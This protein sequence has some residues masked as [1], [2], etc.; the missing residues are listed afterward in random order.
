MEST[1]IK[2]VW[3]VSVV[4]AGAVSVQQTSLRKKIAATWWNVSSYKLL[5]LQTKSIKH[6]KK[7]SYHM[8][9][10]CNS[11]TIHFSSY[12]QPTMMPN[13]KIALF[14]QVE[15]VTTSSD[16]SSHLLFGRV[17]SMCTKETALTSLREGKIVANS[18][19]SVTCRVS[20]TLI[21]WR[22]LIQNR[23]KLSTKKSYLLL[24]H[25]S[26]CEWKRQNL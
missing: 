5:W 25:L 19:K 2:F 4:V 20:I 16:K 26:E 3:L 21:K 10:P 14:S 7:N 22:I 15:W 12:L 1:R 6:L 23:T 24:I 18:L 11:S 17:S 13:R 9:S 8:R